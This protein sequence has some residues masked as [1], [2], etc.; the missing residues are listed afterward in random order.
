MCG[1]AVR[2][3]EDPLPRAAKGERAMNYPFTDPVSRVGK[4]DLEELLRS[5]EDAWAEQSGS[6]ITSAE[7]FD[8][9]RRG[10]FDSMFHMAWASYYESW[11]AD[12]RRDAKARV[13]DLPGALLA[14]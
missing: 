10:E 6:R 7:F 3:A 11:R 5:F 1:Y 2:R 4:A 13:A 12:A 14:H 8:L 9:Y